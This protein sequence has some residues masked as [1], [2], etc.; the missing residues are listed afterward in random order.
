[1]ISETNRY[2]KEIENLNSNNRD[3]SLTVTMRITTP[4]GLDADKKI[5]KFI[6]KRMKDLKE[7]F[8]DFCDDLNDDL[9]F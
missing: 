4:R 1:M 8:K 5:K 6:Q 2:T 9:E 3:V 7:E